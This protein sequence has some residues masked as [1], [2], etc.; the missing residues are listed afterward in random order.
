MTKD[1]ITIKNASEISG[2]SIQTIRRMINLKRLNLKKKRLLKD[3]I[4]LL[5]LKI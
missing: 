2:K 3:L 5:T 1:F 4:T